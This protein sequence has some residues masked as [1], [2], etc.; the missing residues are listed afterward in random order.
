MEKDFSGHVATK[1]GDKNCFVPIVS[2]S[3]GEIK[4]LL[5]YWLSGT[6]T[7]TS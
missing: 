1:G 3:M 4:Q 5:N 7:G 6:F 2:V